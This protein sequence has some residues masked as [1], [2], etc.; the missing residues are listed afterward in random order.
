MAISS[1]NLKEIL[2][3]FKAQLDDR[4]DAFAQ[5]LTTSISIHEISIHEISTRSRSSYCG[6]IW[7]IDP[8]QRSYEFILQG[9]GGALYRELPSREFLTCLEVGT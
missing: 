6:R 8:K 4:L 7:T 1:Q 3:S 2:E 9:K 5:G